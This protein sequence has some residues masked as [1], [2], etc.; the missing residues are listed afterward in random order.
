MPKTPTPKQRQAA[1]KIIE[2]QRIDKPKDL[3]VVLADIG[4]SKGIQETPSI[5]I[6][7]Q[8]FKQAI[9]DMGL[10]E[11][12]ITSS[13]VKDIKK[14]PK[15]RLGELRLGAEILGMKQDED[16]PQQKSGNTYNIFFSK[17]I[18]ENVKLL[19]DK[20]KERLKNVQTP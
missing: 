9:R 12:L 8:G 10:T 6:E 15:N 2:N 4:Y 1:K 13:L 14:K 5:V 11:E 18:Q 16:K 20:I 19:E 7:S 3:G 17:E